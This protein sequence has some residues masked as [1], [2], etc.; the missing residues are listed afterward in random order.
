MSNGI[1]LKLNSYFKVSPF[2]FFLDEPNGTERIGLDF[3]LSF[4]FFTLLELD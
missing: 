2:F 3:P 4:F 1:G